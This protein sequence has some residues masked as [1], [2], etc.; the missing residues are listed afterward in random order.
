[1]VIKMEEKQNSK[2]KQILKEYGVFIL[3]IILIIGIRI[4]ICTPINVNGSSMSN[5]LKDGD[6]MLL[7]KIG[8]RTKKLKRFDIVVV[9]T[10]HSY[11][12]KRIIGLPGETISYKNEKLY[13]NGKAVEDKYNLNNTGDFDAV[14]IGKNEYF[15]M[16]DNRN[17]SNDSRVIGPVEKKDII[18]KTN[19]VIF[20]FK[21]FGKVES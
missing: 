10:S 2:I 17:V 9:R 4:F 16:G 19:F 8:L 3:I 12:I 6:I 15:V 13:I 14:K 11:I 20:P 5:T 1:M 7:N 18:G 21:K